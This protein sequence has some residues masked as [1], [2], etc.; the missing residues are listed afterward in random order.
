MNK[1]L[2][3]KL[4][5]KFPTFFRDMYK[6]YRISS[7][8]FGLECADGWF[9]IIWGMCEKINKITE[10]NKK[11]K[12]AFYFTQIK[13]KWGFLNAYNTGANEEIWL[14]TDEAEKESMKVCEFCGSK[15]NVTTE[16]GWLKTLCQN[17]RKEP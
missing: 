11:L 7:L 16:G 1:N 4:I 9:N 14:I 6:D 2:E 5:E 17:C 3:N 13:E 12:K 8:C 15:E 10:K